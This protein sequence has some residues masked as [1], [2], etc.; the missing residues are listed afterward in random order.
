MLAR[1][2]SYSNSSHV[3]QPWFLQLMEG[4]LATYDEAKERVKSAFPN[5]SPTTNQ[6]ASS[7]IAGFFG[8]YLLMKLHSCL[9][10][11]ILLRFDRFNDRLACKKARNWVMYSKLQ[12]IS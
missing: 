11:L 2:Q 5:I 10:L 1:S 7:A 3:S 6:F 8:D 4:M 12:S 9:F